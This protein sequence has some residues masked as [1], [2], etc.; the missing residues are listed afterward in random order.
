MGERWHLGFEWNYGKD[1]FQI[2]EI[3]CCAWL[4][5]VFL[6]EF[7]WKVELALEIDFYYIIHICHG[8]DYNINTSG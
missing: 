7:F 5:I 4:E 6:A 3:D 1:A 2:D 8:H